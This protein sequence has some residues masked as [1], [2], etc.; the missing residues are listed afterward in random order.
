MATPSIRRA[1]R[2][3]LPRLVAMLGELFAIEEDFN[4]SPERQQRGLDL[5]LQTDSAAV[6][7]AVKERSVIGMVSGQIVISTAEGGSSLLVEDLFVD[8]DF[9]GRGV[10]RLL[11]EEIGGWAK[12]KGAERMQ[13]LADITNRDGL[14]FY[15][16]CG[17]NSTQL[18]CLRKY[19]TEG[20]K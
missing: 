6:L 13:L 18:K 4:F 1:T 8:L 9:R 14:A 5:L 2:V 20:S 11:L 19:Y 7:V 12:G 10:G 16:H 15:N 3:E 17:W